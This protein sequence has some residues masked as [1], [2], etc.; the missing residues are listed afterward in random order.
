MK[1]N[2]TNAEPDFTKLEQL[3]RQSD[4][5]TDV[6]SNLHNNI[7]QAVKASAAT[8][9]IISFQ[10]IAKIVLPLAACLAVVMGIGIHESHHKKQAPAP[11]P[12]QTEIQLTRAAVITPSKISVAISQIPLTADSTMQ[13]E[14][15]A[16]KS[17]I[18]ATARC[19]LASIN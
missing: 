1:N 5:S 12:N 3:L 4:I 15:N 8:K 10:A 14:C 13:K 16:L 2:K 19:L 18:R 11:Q 9:H 7:M 6:P 17:D